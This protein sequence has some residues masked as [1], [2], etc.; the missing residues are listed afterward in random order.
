VEADCENPRTCSECKLT[1]GE[2]LGHSWQDATTEN[3]KTCENCGL[4]EGERIVTDP[5]FTT[6]S[7]AALQGK[8]SCD[9][10]V[11]GDMI[12]EP[13]FDGTL[14]YALVLEL[15]PDGTMAMYMQ[16][17]DF[18]ALREYMLEL[19]YEEF[20]ASGLDKEGADAALKESTGM[21]VEQYVDYALG[22]IDFDS[23]MGSINFEGV[24]Y[25]EGDRLY[26]GLTWDAQLTGDLFTLEGDTLTLVTTADGQ[27]STSVFVRV[28]D[29][30]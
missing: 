6:A 4:T 1:E 29:V 8:W 28:T 13:G 19:M 22:M 23:L 5:R 3:P 20:E 10:E 24:Y 9:I 12:G 30:E 25:V 15:N 14:S 27:E 26:S 11:T 21:T 7:T 2:A 18:S 17:K 16:L